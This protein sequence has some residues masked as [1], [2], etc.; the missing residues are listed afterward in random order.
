ML[1]AWALIAVSYWNALG[2]EF[3]YDDHLQ[4][5][6]NPLIQSPALWTTALTTD[7][8]SFKN[9]DLRRSSNYYRPTFSAWLIV[10]YTLFRTWAGGWHLGNILLHGLATWL[11]FLVLRRLKIVP[12]GTAIITWLFACHPIHVESVTWVSGSPDILLACAL[13][14]SLIAYLKVR[15]E[16]SLKLWLLV[17]LGALLGVGSKE[18]GALFFVVIAVT[19]YV[20]SRQ[21][22]LPKP[23]LRAAKAALPFLAV[24]IGFILFRYKVTGQF[25]ASV[26]NTLTNASMFASIPQAIAFYLRQAFIPY[27]LSSA[28]P[29]RTLDIG[30]LGFGNFWAPLFFVLSALAGMVWAIRRNPI[31]A[32]GVT[33]LVF[34]LP[35]FYFRALHPEHMVRDRYFYLP[36]FAVLVAVACSIFHDSS[37]EWDRFRW[38]RASYIG[39][40]LAFILACQSMSY[41]RVWLNDAA[42]WGRG[43]E[44]DPNGTFALMNVCDALRVRNRPAEAIP[45]GLRSIALKP[46]APRAHYIVGLAYKELHDFKNT[47]KH[48]AEAV[49]LGGDSY[50][51]AKP[52]GDLMVSQNRLDEAEQLYRRS[53]KRS[54]SYAPAGTVNLAEVL[55]IQGK[56]DEAF[57]LLKSREADRETILIPEVQRAWFVLGRIYQ[58][59]DNSVEANKC[60]QKYRERTE[61]M[62]GGD[63]R[64]LR[65]AAKLYIGE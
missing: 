6:K 59:F 43:V 4:V 50:V 18:A 9:A 35:S 21:E 10:N 61:G 19:E 28:Y 41:S 39:L 46:K 5:Q 25:G 49:R 20:L 65:D 16:P 33:F 24:A 52:L 45:F 12:I 64:A 37:V 42:L 51:A 56:A 44:T 62:M 26:G 15:K 48:F 7:V 34:V 55:L 47:E 60:F 53:I 27:E 54:S 36:L 31:A 38:T 11:G 17:L 32:I 40:G 58:A 1:V 2:G 57:A 23:F 8:W 13:F 22:S 30:S 14:F 29:M 63:I 3:V